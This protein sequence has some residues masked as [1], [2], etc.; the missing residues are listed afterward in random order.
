MKI[1]LAE[2]HGIGADGERDVDAIVDD[3]PRAGFVTDR[4]ASLAT[5]TM[6][7]LRRA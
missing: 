2:V 7:A 4:R 6:S 3:E 1:G 5:R